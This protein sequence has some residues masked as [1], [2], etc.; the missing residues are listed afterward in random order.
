MRRLLRVPGGQGDVRS[1][2]CRM[3]ARCPDG[4][5]S[6][7][8]METRRRE[9]N[10]RNGD[11]K[12]HVRPD[13]Q[14]FAC[15]S[16]TASHAPRVA[17]VNRAHRRHRLRGAN[18]ACSPAATTAPRWSRKHAGGR[19]PHYQSAPPAAAPHPEARSAGAPGPRRFP[20]RRLLRQRRL[21]HSGVL[22]G[23][24]RLRHV[25]PDPAS[26]GSPVLLRRRRSRELHRR[27]SVPPHRD[28]RGLTSMIGDAGRC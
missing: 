24:V 16:I 20:L 6:G 23:P 8:A 22:H 19:L 14:E 13:R 17:G 1:P 11:G 2:R 10:E 27:R 28:R 25:Q 15:G 3:I 4:E 26:P 18:G 9:A 5:G 21:R 12:P 7:L